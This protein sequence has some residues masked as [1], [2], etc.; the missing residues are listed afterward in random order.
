MAD[1]HFSTIC[2]EPAKAIFKADMIDQVLQVHT[3]YM[4]WSRPCSRN[5][6]RSAAFQR[7][8]AACK[9]EVSLNVNGRRKATPLPS[10]FSPPVRWSNTWPV[11]VSRSKSSWQVL[12]DP[13]TRGTIQMAEG[14][15]QGNSHGL[16]FCLSDWI[17]LMKC[18]EVI[19]LNDPEKKKKWLYYIAEGDEL[20]ENSKRLRC[21]FFFF[22]LHHGMQKF[23]GQ[24]SNPS[25]G[26][27]NC[28]TLNQ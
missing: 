5:S 25:H 13:W 28:Q 8:V 17:S 15:H 20:Q 23:Q 24:G 10:G 12:S 6:Q 18:Q 16:Q 2:T 14:Q 22:W 21:L 27:D 11:T 7:E 4:P 3:D 26:S 9:A 19:E 1:P